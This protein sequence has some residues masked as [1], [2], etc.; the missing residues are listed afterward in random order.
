MNTIL[1]DELKSDTILESHVYYDDYFIVFPKYHRITDGDIKMA[2]QHNLS[3]L[4]SSTETPITVEEGSPEASEESHEVVQLEKKEAKTSDVSDSMYESVLTSLKSIFSKAEKGEHLK[5]EDI[6]KIAESTIE[7]S[8]NRTE[9]ALLRISR[10]MMPEHRLEVHSLNTGILCAL[11]ASDVDMQ[12]NELVDM[13]AGAL[14]HDIGILLLNEDE[15][16]NEVR[17]HTLFGFQY[18]EAFKEA[19]PSMVTPSLQHHEKGDGSGYPNQLLLESIETS[20]RLVAI[21]DSCDSNVSYLRFGQ[22]LSLH[23][24]KEDL[25]SWK[26]EDFDP[27]HFDRFIKTITGVFRP[28]RRVMLSDE[29]IGI[30]K[31][32]LMRFP[33]NPVIEV[34]ADSIGVG[35]ENPETIELV[36]RKDLWIKEL[37]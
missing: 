20:A 1:L 7:Y 29:N 18:L 2:R 36:K 8:L 11:L 16:I 19:H 31:K 28:G 37:S 30:I 33:L 35:L 9:E 3:P 32:T 5:L 27:E 22:D 24:T 26:K 4:F 23:M 34:V 6:N 21:C 14:I 12:E 13:V 10:G 25:F 17:K 15:K